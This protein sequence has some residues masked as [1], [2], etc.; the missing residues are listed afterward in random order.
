MVP[1]S[2]DTF[3]TA[4]SLEAHPFDLDLPVRLLRQV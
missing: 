4:L 2:L 1:V 3:A